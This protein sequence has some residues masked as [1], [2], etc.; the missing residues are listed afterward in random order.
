MEEKISESRRILKKAW[1]K[2]VD[3]Q[4]LYW[5]VLSLKRLIVLGKPYQELETIID[6]I[7]K[8]L[9]RTRVTIGQV[10]TIHESEKLSKKEK[11]FLENILNELSIC[12]SLIEDFKNNIELGM[13]WSELQKRSK[14]IELRFKKIGEKLTK[15]SIEHYLDKKRGEQK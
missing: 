7:N 11:G 4:N 13:P 5:D 14:E 2:F 10:Y 8:F 3:I 15:K 12:H 1:G 9:S 6:E